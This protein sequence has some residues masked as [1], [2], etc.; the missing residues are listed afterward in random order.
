[1][2]CKRKSVARNQ[3]TDI[4]CAVMFFAVVIST[5]LLLIVLIAHCYSNWL[6]WALAML[7]VGGFRMLMTIFRRKALRLE[8]E[9]GIDHDISN[10]EVQLII[11]DIDRFAKVQDS[12]RL[13]FELAPK[14]LSFVVKFSKVKFPK[15]GEV[16]S[17]SKLISTRMVLSDKRK[18]R[19]LAADDETVYCVHEDARD[20]CVYRILLEVSKDP[21]PYASDIWHYM[22][23]R[24][25]K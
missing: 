11:R 6:F 21:M 20:E 16:Y 13:P 4:V 17:R 24:F 15:V 8:C 19:I 23:M 18:F 7:F 1:M 9:K 12:E 25:Y 3:L 22:A 2:R 5:L 10:D 14:I